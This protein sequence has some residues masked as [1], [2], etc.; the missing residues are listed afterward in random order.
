MIHKL[1]QTCKAHTHITSQP[2]VV[3]VP[4]GEAIA[5]AAACICGVSLLSPRN[6]DGDDRAASPGW[7]VPAPSK[8]LIGDL[9]HKRL[10]TFATRSRIGNKQ[11]AITAVPHGACQRLSPE[12]E[13]PNWNTPYREGLS[14]PFNQQTKSEDSLKCKTPKTKQA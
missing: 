9:G 12:S 3:V 1:W 2:Q 10:T 11:R 8:P 7:G 4:L 5:A 6:S 14:L 13:T